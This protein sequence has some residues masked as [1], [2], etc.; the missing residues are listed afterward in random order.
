MGTLTRRREAARILTLSP[1]LAARAKTTRVLVVPDDDGQLDVFATWTE[2]ADGFDV[3]EPLL[4]F[5][6]ID[7]AAIRDLY[8]LATI[9]AVQPDPQKMARVGGARP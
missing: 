7:H 3:T 8:D 6:W 5:S 4:C 2:T 9:G 1:A